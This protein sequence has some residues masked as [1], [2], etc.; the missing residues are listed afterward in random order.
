MKRIAI[1]MLLTWSAAAQAPD[2]A[3]ERAQ[4]IHAGYGK[5]E[6]RIPARD[7]KR[8]F[9]SVYVPNGVHFGK[10][11]P[12]LLMRTPYSAAPYGLDRYRD[13]LAPIIDYEKE[14]YIFAFQDV[15]GR[16]MS[17]GEFVN[18][19]PCLDGAG[20]DEAT[21]TYDSIEWLVKNVPGNSGRV[22]MWGISYPGFYTACGAIQGHPALKAISPQAPIADWFRGDDMHRN[23]AFNLQMAF[24]FFANFGKP[25]PEPS[26]VPAKNYEYPTNDAYQFFLELGPV[27]NALKKFG[28]ANAFWEEMSRHPN[29]DSY[30]QSRNLLPHLRGIKAATLVVAGWFDTE[31][32]YGPL[33]IYQSIRKQNPGIPVHLVVGPWFHGGW[34]RA[35]GKTLGAADF[36][37]TTSQTYQK[38]E[39][40][41]FQQHLKGTEPSGLAG[42]WVFETGANRWRS[43]PSWPPPQAQPLDLFMSSQGKLATKASQADGHDEFVS[44]P[45]RPVPY[46]ADNSSIR[47]SKDYMAEDQRFAARRPDV[48][49]YQ[50][51]SLRDDLTIAG[52]IE[53]SLWVSTSRQDADWVVKLI[54]VNPGKLAVDDEKYRGGQQTLVRGEPMRGRFR[55]SFEHPKPFEPDRPTRVHFTLNDVCHT[56]MRNHRVM[57]QVQSSW[58]PYIDRN[59][60]SWVG[61]LFEA[62]PEDFVKATHRL[63]YGDDH[64]SQ[65]RLYKLGIDQLK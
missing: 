64:P 27:G 14:G 10:K 49:V 32:L 20:V 35:E 62:R 2:P 22:G 5:Y 28:F 57:V 7:G 16:W 40:A 26:E 33:H 11:Y 21:D 15:R 1:F 13:S 31:D 30:W 25:R 53:V 29:Y 12:I 19:R 41:F 43:F 37:T 48:L 24:G 56:F 50:G 65:L 6:F 51:E 36:G 3:R 47:Q 59:P 34:W 23:G 52:P 55:E 18:M 63:Y 42:A 38:A 4:A 58:F 39:L 46:T 8:L 17:E 54:D 45:A 44:D 9:T 61:N 60:Q